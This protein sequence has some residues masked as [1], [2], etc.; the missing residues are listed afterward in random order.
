MHLYVDALLVK[1]RLLR[2]RLDQFEGF[3]YKHRL[4]AMKKNHRHTLAKTKRYR[5]EEEILAARKVFM[6]PVVVESAQKIR[7]LYFKLFK[8][9]FDLLLT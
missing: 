9:L 6:F 8:T 7:E 4:G 3:V 2:M 1:H 5:K